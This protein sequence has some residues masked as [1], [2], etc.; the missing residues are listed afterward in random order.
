MHLQLLVADLFLDAEALEGQATVSLPRLPALES[1]LRLGAARP[2]PAGWRAA[3]AQ[4]LGLGQTGELPPAHLAAAAL[5]LPRDA[6]V[7]EAAQRV[8]VEGVEGNVLVVRPIA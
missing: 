8:R 3:L 2:N 5:R 1:L 7:P 4:A 6:K